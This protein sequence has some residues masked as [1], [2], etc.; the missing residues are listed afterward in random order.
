[1]RK[2][3]N[4]IAS[5]LEG[6]TTAAI[7]GHVRPDG[8]CVGSCMGMYLYLKE[9]YPQIQTDVYLEEVPEVFHFIQDIDQAKQECQQHRP[10]RRCRS[11]SEYGENNRVHRPSHHE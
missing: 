7:A 11:G 6:V 3:I 9:N 10:D 4:N 5:V 1:M 8:D 2:M